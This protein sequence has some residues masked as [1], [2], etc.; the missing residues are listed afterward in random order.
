MFIFFYLNFG[1]EY[2][3]GFLNDPLMPDGHFRMV[4]FQF[5]V[6]CVYLIVDSDHYHS[7]FGSGSK[8]PEK[9]IGI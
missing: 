3:S 9:R 6:S 4:H 2:T 8:L 1:N 7:A 5:K